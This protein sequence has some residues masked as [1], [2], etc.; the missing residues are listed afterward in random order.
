MCAGT[1]KIFIFEDSI[2]KDLGF[3]W[4]SGMTAWIINDWKSVMGKLMI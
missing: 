4:I 3:G 2:R 1:Y